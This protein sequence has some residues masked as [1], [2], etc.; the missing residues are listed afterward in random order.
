V[1]AAGEVLPADVTAIAGIAG[2][3]PGG[4]RLHRLPTASSISPKR[5]DPA[6]PAARDL[7]T[8]ALPPSLQLVVWVAV[9][10]VPAG[11]RLRAPL[12]VV[13]APDGLAAH[14]E[15]IAIIAT[16]NGI[17]VQI[18]LSARPLRPRHATCRRGCAGGP[19]T[20]PLNATLLTA[21]AVLLLAC[22]CRSSGWRTDSR[23]TLVMFALVNPRWR[24]SRYA[25]P[26]YHLVPQ[27]CCGRLGEL[28]DPGGIDTFALVARAP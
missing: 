14:H 12:A 18:I 16:L 19:V 23:I 10:A 20:A 17:I 9:V 24:A 5:K 28:R 25:A 7:L 22:C 3:S 4:V 2:A 15:L 6:H 1:T 11:S 27:R 13:R 26:Q 8:L 21:L